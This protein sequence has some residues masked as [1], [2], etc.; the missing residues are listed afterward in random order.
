MT[1]TNTGLTVDLLQTLIRNQCV[2]EGTVESG[3]ESR[4]ADVLETYLEGAGIAIER[5]EAAPGRVSLVGKIEGTDP[6][7]PSLLLNGHTDVV[8][9]NPDGWTRDP[10]GGEL[11]DGEVWGRGAVDMLN[12]TSS[13]AVAARIVAN[14]KKRLRGDLIFFAVADEENGS[15]YGARYMGEHHPE[16]IT[17]DYVLT[18]NGGLHSEGADGR[19]ITVNIGEKGIG[20]NRLTVRGTPGHGSQPFKS[21]NALMKAAAIVQRIGEFQPPARMHEL[22]RGQV[23]AMPFDDETK[24]ALLDPDRIDETLASMPK[25]SGAGFLH[26][27][28]HTTFSPN[29]IS[30]QHKTNV[31]PDTVHIEV[32]TR[33][34]PGDGHEE[35]K[36]YLREA[37]GDLADHVEIEPLLSEPSSMSP[38]GNP[39]W[40]SLQKAVN[41]PYPD[42]R[43]DPGFIVGFTD[44]R[45]H[46]ELGAITYGAGLFADSLTKAEYGSRFHGNNERIDVESLGL[47]T[48]LWLDVIDDL[49]G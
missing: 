14:R 2:N 16:A 13:M 49:L 33:T 48:Q 27:C 17:A 41:N 36:A 22:W 46:R 29:V 1:D 20:W 8:P 19:T 5:F 23:A 31:I 43:I 37:M 11:I 15:K 26:A 25:A 35:V 38:M 39:L 21:D 24:A 30:S 6:D 28:T 4:N 9:A 12:L 7:A 40:D 44:A 45:V 10:F 47:T 32:D 34:M 3:H 18:E 42:A